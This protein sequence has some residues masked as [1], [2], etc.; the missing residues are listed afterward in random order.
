L[1][2]VQAGIGW[3]TGK[4]ATQPLSRRVRHGRKIAMSAFESPTRR[5]QSR[6]YSDPDDA[7]GRH[8]LKNGEPRVRR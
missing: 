6:F 3:L 1:R 5:A 7:E 2:D 4:T 8:G